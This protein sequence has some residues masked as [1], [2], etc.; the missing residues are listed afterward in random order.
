MYE[1]YSRHHDSWNTE[2][3]EEL[4]AVTPS[5]LVISSSSTSVGSST[6]DDHK[7]LDTTVQY[8]HYWFLAV[9]L[10]YV[11]LLLTLYLN[12]DVTKNSTSGVMFYYMN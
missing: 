4:L 6:R 3:P 10:S 12:L 9:M 2:V 1:S 8:Y 11:K 5:R 7:S